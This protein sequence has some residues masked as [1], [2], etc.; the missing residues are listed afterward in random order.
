[1]ND[2]QYQQAQDRIKALAKQAPDLS[3]EEL[4][5][6]EDLMEACQEYQD[7]LDADARAE[8]DNMVAFEE[9]LMAGQ[10]R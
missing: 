6:L 5:E 4:H 9:R 8:Y 10:D 7:A 1:M 3:W 2:A